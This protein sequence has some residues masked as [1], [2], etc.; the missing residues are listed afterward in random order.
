MCYNL[1]LSG[2]ECRQET[3]TKSLKRVYWN[4]KKQWGNSGEKH[5][6]H[7]EKIL[8]IPCTKEESVVTSSSEQNN[9]NSWTS[10]KR[11]SNW[12][13]DYHKI[14]KMP[15]H[16]WTG[17]QGLNSQLISNGRFQ[18]PYQACH[19]G[20]GKDHAEDCHPRYSALGIHVHSQFTRNWKQHPRQL[21]DCSTFVCHC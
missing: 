20:P 18:A 16:W 17:A 9:Y 5:A 10:N 12:F 15:R 1:V 8:H 7:K 11:A 2:P 6:R 13:H 4:Q 21:L 3:A 19:D 14:D